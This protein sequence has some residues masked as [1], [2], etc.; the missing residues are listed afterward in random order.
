[1]YEKDSLIKAVFYTPKK[2]LLKLGVNMK[3]VAIL[4]ANPAFAEHLYVSKDKGLCLCDIDDIKPTL[5]CNMGYMGMHNRMD[6]ECG[7]I[8]SMHKFQ[9]WTLNLKMYP[10]GQD[11]RDEL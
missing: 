3:V 4:D 5:V 1:M 8:I 7:G 10:L 11:G 6:K 2:L 9:Q